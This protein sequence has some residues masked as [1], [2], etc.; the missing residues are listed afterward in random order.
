LKGNLAMTRHDAG[1]TLRQ[2]ISVSMSGRHSVL[3]NVT[4]SAYDIGLVDRDFI[5]SIKLML[6]NR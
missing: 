2:T 3:L 1:A 5:E 6:N 4:K